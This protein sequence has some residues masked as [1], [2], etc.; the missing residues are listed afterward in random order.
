MTYLLQF[1]GVSDPLQLFYLEQ[2]SGGSSAG[3]R[4]GPSFGGF[5]P[6]QLD[7]LLAWALE[8]GRGRHWD[9][10]VIQRTV[11]DVWMERAE[12][13]R[14]WQLRL[15]EEPADHLLV[16]GIGTPRDWEQRCEELLQ[17]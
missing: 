16:A 5:R 12:A 3:A 2:R 8:T 17:A 10:E 6:F 9:G 1:F 4:R 14:Q 13:I 11:V 7:D 15:R